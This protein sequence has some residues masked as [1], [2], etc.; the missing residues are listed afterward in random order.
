[1]FYQG[2]NRCSKVEGDITPFGISDAYKA[3]KNPFGATLNGNE[4]NAIRAMAAD[5]SDKSNLGDS[6]QY[7]FR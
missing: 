4:K 5:A 1:M 7:S 3:V 2:K 6:N